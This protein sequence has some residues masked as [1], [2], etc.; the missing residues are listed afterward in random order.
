M[1]FIECLQQQ[2]HVCALNGV[3]FGWGKFSNWCFKPSSLIGRE[4]HRARINLKTFFRKAKAKCQKE[5]KAGRRKHKVALPWCVH[6]SDGKK[7]LIR[8]RHCMCPSGWRNRDKCL[9]PNVDHTVP[10]SFNDP[11]NSTDSDRHT[12]SHF[13]VE[14]NCSNKRV[15]LVFKTNFNDP[16]I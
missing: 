16:Y 1:D 14:L 13:T 5:T 8:N 11:Y 4:R 12:D 6:I 15:R 9:S 7:V 10:C 2:E 3:A